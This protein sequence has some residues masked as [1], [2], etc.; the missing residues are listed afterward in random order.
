MKILK[1]RDDYTMKLKE[2]Q[3]ANHIRF[4]MIFF[5]IICL[6]S[7][8]SVIVRKSGH[9]LPGL[10][11]SMVLI[12]LIILGLF[13]W[14]SVKRYN[15]SLARTV[16]LGI[17]LSLGSHWT[18]PLF[19]KGWEILQLLIINSAIFAFIAFLGGVIAVIVNRFLGYGKRINE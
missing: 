1:N 13:G 14:L 8:V 6:G 11:N 18:L 15:L 9:S 7:F 19:H 3:T 16:L 2:N 5:F 12:T 17:I 4:I 10:Q